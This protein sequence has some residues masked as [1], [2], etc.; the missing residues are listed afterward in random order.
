MARA[1][2]GFDRRTTQVPQ[3][4]SNTESIAACA[5]M[6]HSLSGRSQEPLLAFVTSTRLFQRARYNPVFFSLD[7][8]T[9]ATTTLSSVNSSAPSQCPTTILW[10]CFDAFMLKIIWAMPF[11][12]VVAGSSTPPGTKLA[13]IFIPTSFGWAAGDVS[14]AA[15]IRSTLA[16]LESKDPDVSTLGAVMAFLY[17]I[18]IVLYSLLSAVLGN[19]VHAYL[20]KNKP[21]V[22]TVAAAREALKYVGGVQFTHPW[23]RPLPTSHPPAPWATP[24]LAQQP[25]V[26]HTARAGDGFGFECRLGR[27]LRLVGMWLSPKPRRICWRKQR[28]PC[29]RCRAPGNTGG[30]RE[31]CRS[32]GVVVLVC[33]R[34]ISP[35]YHAHLG[36]ALFMEDADT[37]RVE[38]GCGT[39]S[40]RRG[41]GALTCCRIAVPAKLFVRSH[42]SHRDPQ[43][44]ALARQRCADVIRQRFSNHPKLKVP[45]VVMGSNVTVFLFPVSVHTCLIAEHTS[46]N[47]VVDT[48]VFVGTYPNR[49]PA[50]TFV[51]N[52]TTVC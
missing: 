20:K 1:C 16:K 15:Y 10:L 24:A 18:Y 19:W 48:V 38:L 43:G 42:R 28:I 13:T 26:L 40:V 3:S 2:L 31:A 52:V 37:A 41:G 30:T 49:S 36:Q 12:P 39:A 47:N 7:P 35:S 27:L 6:S 50:A 32:L 17:V 22:D 4:F 33:E 44:R 51:Y 29:R 21:I 5:L 23:S 45:S 11:L 34:Q 25:L 14:L 9:S 8:S 46:L